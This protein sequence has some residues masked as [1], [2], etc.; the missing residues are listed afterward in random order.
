ME[1]AERKG[2]ARRRDSTCP[3]R[4][5]RVPLPARASAVGV[6]RPDHDREPR[7]DVDLED[8]IDE[9]HA[10]GLPAVT[11]AVDEEEVAE[12]SEEHER[13]GVLEAIAAELL[14]GLGGER[15]ER[16]GE[17]RTGAD[18]RDELVHERERV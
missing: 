5:I 10:L 1:P 2:L 18:D 14:D 3:P 4:K 7:D 6:D 8:P 16:V 11:A 12:D 15:V 17:D 13:D 9:Q